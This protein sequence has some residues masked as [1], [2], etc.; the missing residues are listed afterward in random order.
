MAV[1]ECRSPEKASGTLCSWRSDRLCFD[2]REVL[3]A[4]VVTA[5]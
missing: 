1:P 2:L 4:L 3:G 5:S